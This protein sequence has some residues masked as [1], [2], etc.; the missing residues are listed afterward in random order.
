MVILMIIMILLVYYLINNKRSYKIGQIL[1]S[2]KGYSCIRILDI[3]NK[4]NIIWIKYLNHDSRQICTQKLD[5][6]LL[7]YKSYD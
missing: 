7:E 3:Q 2:K 4:E 5:L 1:Y 6:L